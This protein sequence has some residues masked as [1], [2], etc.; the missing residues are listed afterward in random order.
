MVNDLTIVQL[1]YY[2]LHL[3]ITGVDISVTVVRF[4][5]IFFYED[6]VVR[7]RVTDERYSSM[8]SL[9]VKLGDTNEKRDI[10]SPG[11]PRNAISL[12]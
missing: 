1:Q 5:A 7:V 8:P 12:L 9:C 3:Y 10:S 4:R 11:A 2:M 6:S